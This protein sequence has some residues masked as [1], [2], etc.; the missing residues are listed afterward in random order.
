VRADKRAETKGKGAA[1]DLYPVLEHDLLGHAAGG[2]TVECE[3]NA[4]E[5]R[6]VRGSYHDERRRGSEEGLGG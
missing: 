1:T 6:G 3:L 2:R 4:C 5:E